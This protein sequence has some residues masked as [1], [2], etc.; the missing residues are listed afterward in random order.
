MELYVERQREIAM[1]DLHQ[2]A[3]QL[4]DVTTRIASFIHQTQRH[5]DQTLVQCEILHA[6]VQ[7]FMTEINDSID[8]SLT[9]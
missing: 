6:Q 7:E 4:Q 1:Q 2:T 5:I 3:T 8:T 9:E